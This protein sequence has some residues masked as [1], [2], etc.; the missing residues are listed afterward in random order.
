MRDGV[1]TRREGNKWKGREVGEV[2]GFALR[3][4]EERRNVGGRSLALFQGHS[5]IGNN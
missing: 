1:I 3:Y 5:K 2:G 4:K